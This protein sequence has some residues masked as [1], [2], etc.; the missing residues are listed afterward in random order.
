MPAAS[1]NE[2]VK[3]LNCAK[4]DDAQCKTVAENGS[5][6]VGPTD[7]AEYI[8][9][10]ATT[11]DIKPIEP[12][13]LGINIPDLT[14]SDRLVAVE[15][16]FTIP[17]F[18]Q[19]VSA[20]NTYLLG[21]TA[22]AAAI[23][24]VYGGFLYIV[25]STIPGVA[26][27][28]EIIKDTL[29]GL[30][31]LLG[32]YAMLSTLNPTLT[33]PQGI[34]IKSISPEMQWFEDHGTGDPIYSTPTI[35]KIMDSKIPGRSTPKKTSVTSKTLVQLLV[36][37]ASAEAFHNV[38]DGKSAFNEILNANDYKKLQRGP[39]KMNA[40]CTTKEEADQATTYNQKIKL[41][42][43]AVLGWAQVCTKD[44][45]CVY[46]QT[47]STGLPDGVPSGAANA[48]FAANALTG[49]NIGV[50]KIWPKDVACQKAWSN[51]S[52]NFKISS[53]SQ[54]I[55]PAQAAYTEYFIN[56]LAKAGLYGTDC[57]GFATH[58]YRCTNAAFTLPPNGKSVSK[59]PP[60]PYLTPIDIGKFDKL[61]TFVFSGHW[62]DADLPEK[63]KKM[64]F[65]DLVY[66]CCGGSE[67]PYNAHWFMYTDGH[68]DVPFSFIEMGGVTKDE[69]GSGANVDGYGHV[70]GVVT[71]P[72]GWTIMDYLKPKM[73]KIDVCSDEHC[74]FYK[75]CGSYYCKG[76]KQIFKYTK[77][78][79][80]KALIWV[81]RPFADV[82]Q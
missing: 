29:I 73:P 37:A 17:W 41:L 56:N 21:I 47:C 50:E 55:A 3:K 38:P 14:F 13:T 45:K 77:N 26:R 76:G 52:K 57:S 40:F 51:K 78:D 2:D 19:Y 43:K 1:K 80:A 49:H 9:Q 81:W 70:P 30:L 22:V 68:P 27:G 6:I 69:K 44:R 11:E 39:Q 65:G 28:K 48:D 71:Q 20:I 54:C 60:T 53:I 18:A 79:P 32:S 46:C 4:L 8:P 31:L 63:A 36:S 23:M 59:S 61:P 72:P 5:C 7:E 67:D 24:L 66:T 15:G 82:Q 74:G 10:V 25:G 42:V 58:L 33:V 75:Q 62:G 64:K 16:F 34:R 12:P 35:K